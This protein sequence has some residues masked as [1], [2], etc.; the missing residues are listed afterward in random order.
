MVT[1]SD[2]VVQKNTMMKCDEL[3][4]SVLEVNCE[5]GDLFRLCP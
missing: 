1:I 3:Q 4:I 5:R 2:A